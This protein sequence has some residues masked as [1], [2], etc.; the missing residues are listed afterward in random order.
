MVHEAVSAGYY[1]SPLEKSF[2]KIQIL[3]IEGLL[4]GK[5]SPRYP[6][7]A[8][9]GLSFKKAKKEAEKGKQPD[10]F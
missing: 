3:T 9:G 5:Q 7:L 4:S 1:E 6:D 8:K 2:Q 10:L